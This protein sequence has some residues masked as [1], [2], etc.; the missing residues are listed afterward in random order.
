MKANELQKKVVKINHYWNEMQGHV[1]P[2]YIGI[3]RDMLKTQINEF[4]KLLNNERL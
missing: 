4:Q 2:E 1:K 3:H